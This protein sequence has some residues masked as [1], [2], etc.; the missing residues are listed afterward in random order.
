MSEVCGPLGVVDGVPWADSGPSVPPPPS[1]SC[2]FLLRGGVGPRPSGPF[3]RPS[4]AT[5]VL[6]PVVEV[7]DF[8][9]TR[10]ECPLRG[11]VPETESK[12]VL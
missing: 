7:F 9:G 10:T 8:E 3:P 12:C 6:P 1:P 2:S 5:R 4:R 11:R